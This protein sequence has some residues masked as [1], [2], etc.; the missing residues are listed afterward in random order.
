MTI[1]PRRPGSCRLSLALLL[2]SGCAA[3]DDYPSLAPRPIER[4]A[5]AAPEAAAVPAP[6]AAAPDP[7]L[8]ARIAA[9]A[10][11]AQ[12]AD[13]TFAAAADAAGQAIARPGAG[14]SGSDAWIA[15]Q[16][17]YS[18]AVSARG[19]LQDA[20]DALDTLRR[21]QENGNAADIA[22][23]DAAAAQ[24]DGLGAAADVRLAALAQ[25]LR[26]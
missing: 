18:A 19:G 26:D 3:S 10:R 12:A 2:L 22:A 4:R 23:L 20:A 1:I 16:T 5:L 25:R 8:V 13:G 9:I 15:A 11:T 6:E 24:L 14:A 21:A 7:A 17:R